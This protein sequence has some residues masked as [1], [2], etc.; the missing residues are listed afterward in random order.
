MRAGGAVGGEL[1]G[2]G[3][4]GD[5]QRLFGRAHPAEAAEAAAGRGRALR[6]LREGIVA[7]GIEEHD[8]LRRAAERLEELVGL[9]GAAGFLVVAIDFHVGRGD[10]VLAAD[11]HAVAGI[12]GEG[13]RQLVRRLL[14]VLESI[15]KIGPVE[16]V[17]FEDLEAILLQDGGDGF[18]VRNRIFERRQRLVVA[19]PDDER[20]PPRFRRRRQRGTPEAWAA[21]PG[22]VASGTSG[23]SSRPAVWHWPQTRFEVLARGI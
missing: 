10:D 5:E 12:I 14:E 7:A 15:E 23:G 21:R 17:I 8:L 4:V 9:D 22:S 13:D 2:E 16:I 18:G 19:H 11:L 6:T 1:A 20:D 3:G